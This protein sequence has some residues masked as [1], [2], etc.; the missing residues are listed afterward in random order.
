MT[1]VARPNS[2]LVPLLILLI[3]S[4]CWGQSDPVGALDSVVIADVQAF[5]GSDFVL[6]MRLVNDEQIS[7]WSV[8]LS[9]DRELMSLDSVSFVN[10]ISNQWAIQRATI[11]SEQG[12]VLIGALSIDNPLLEPGGGLLAQLYFH[13]AEDRAP[14][15]IGLV[16]SAFIP[17]GGEF[18]LTAFPHANISPAFVSGKL[19]I[20]GG[21]QPPIIM[22]FS[23]RSVR[24]GETLSMAVVAADPEK[25]QTKLSAENLP[26]GS[27]FVYESGD[28]G[29]FVF[30][31]PYTGPGSA[32][33]G[34]YNVTF[35]VTD[36]QTVSKSSLKLDVIDVN[37]P[38]VFEGT[39]S[40]S[41]GSGDTIQFEIAATDPDFDAVTLQS[42]G[43]P[44][45]ASLSGSGPGTFTWFSAV[46]DS[47]DHQFSVIATDA[48]G[49]SS[50]QQFA[51]HLDP[52]TPAAFSF[53][54]AQDENG[55]Q[56]EV[57][58][59]LYNRVELASMHLLVSFDPTAI[60]LDEIISSDTRLADWDRVETTAQPNDGLIWVEAECD[61]TGGNAHVLPTGDG[62]ILRLIFWTSNDFDLAGFYSKID[63]KFLDSDSLTENYVYQ[64]DGVLI[65]KNQLEYNSGG[66]LITAFEGL[67][68]DLNLNDVAFEVGDYVYF[69]NYFTDPIHYPLDGVRWPNSDINQDGIPGTLADLIYMEDIMGSGGPKLA[70]SDDA[71]DGTYA[72][73]ADD[74]N[75]NYLLNFAGQAAGLYCKFLVPASANLELNPN[76]MIQDLDTTSGRT[77]D[78]LRVLVLGHSRSGAHALWGE[79]FSLQSSDNV[80]L[81]SQSLVNSHHQEVT[82]KYDSRSAILPET[83]SLGQ[84]YPNPFNPETMIDFALPQAAQVTLFVYNVLGEQ[85][86]VLKDEHLPAGQYQVRFDGRDDSGATLASGVYFY[87]L[88][89]GTFEETRK[90]VLLK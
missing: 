3:A 33:Q 38:P 50:S 15:E 70:L 18:L 80:T 26:G 49:A 74:A 1:S 28:T 13:A 53:S 64:P 81:V 24:E 75:Y 90:M 23:S 87:R 62:T 8:P 44:A 43:V 42:S 51:I 10:S 88:R 76:K 6:S 60:S 39:S 48:S 55:R 85:V 9:Y 37:R 36:G 30:T 84:N 63:F 2:L 71:M 89:A 77:G 65:N 67:I 57:D 82:L 58:L 86:R 14:G 47:G 78:T 41:A 27:R 20:A 83:F 59:S 40:F 29:I 16:D 73:V 61:T 5:S 21:D 19:T 54:E 31:P 4:T 34:P 52:T 12:T 45:G 56:V 69:Q 46:A 66:V 35:T 25:T 72:L 11:D 7:A 79:L 68:G 17:P 22:P 32:A